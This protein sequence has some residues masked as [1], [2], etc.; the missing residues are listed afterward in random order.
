M[1]LRCSGAALGLSLMPLLVSGCVGGGGSARRACPPPLPP[2]S[3]GGARADAAAVRGDW[4]A[5]IQARGWRARHRAHTVHFPNPSRRTFL[6][7][8]HDAARRYRFAVERVHFYRPFQLAPL[9]IVR[10][11]DPHRLASATPRIQALLDVNPRRRN[12]PG[13]GALYE[14]FYFEARDQSGIPA[15]SVRDFVRGRDPGS[16]M[17]QRS[18]GFFG[19]RGPPLPC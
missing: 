11:E 15:F 17:W 4:V 12:R 13:W 6:V 2:L 1:R 8:L 9:V 3:S 14:G 19:W 16:A 7:R 10:T 5:E 18:T